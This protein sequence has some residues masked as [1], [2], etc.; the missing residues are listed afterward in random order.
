MHTANGSYDAAGPWVVSRRVVPPTEADNV[1][2]GS[3]PIIPTPSTNPEEYLVYLFREGTGTSIANDGVAGAAGDLTISSSSAAWSLDG[4]D[5]P[6]P[7]AMRG[8]A[9]E[10]PNQM[11]WE[12]A[13]GQNLDCREILVELF[14]PAAASPPTAYSLFAYEAVWPAVGITAGPDSGAGPNVGLSQARV[15]H[16]DSGDSGREL[17]YSFPRLSP[18][19]ADSIKQHAIDARRTRRNGSTAPMRPIALL[20]RT[21]DRWRW[22]ETCAIIVPNLP[23]KVLDGSQNPEWEY[24]LEIGGPEVRYGSDA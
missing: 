24:A 14:D 23:R 11:F 5:C 21:A 10:R 13:P 20:K 4:F 8:A 12:L 1:L 2:D 3:V 17:G 6:E 22:P 19:E 18:A 16:G 7:G 15:I 9:S